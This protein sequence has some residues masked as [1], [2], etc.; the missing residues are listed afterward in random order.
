MTS[1]PLRTA[2]SPIFTRAFNQLVPPVKLDAR[3]GGIAP[4]VI[5][6]LD[7]SKLLPTDFL[8]L[9]KRR[10]YVI[11]SPECESTHHGTLAYS[12]DRPFPRGTRG[13]FYFRKAAD[14]E[15]K[16]EVPVIGGSFRF[17]ITPS[18]DPRSFQDGHDLQRLGQPWGQKLIDAVKYPYPKVGMLIRD[19][20]VQR[21]DVQDV[22]ALPD[23][24]P[25]LVYFDQWFT[26]LYGGQR[27]GLRTRVVWRKP[28]GEWETSL[29]D[30]MSMVAVPGGWNTG[31]HG[32]SPIQHGA[33]RA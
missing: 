9:S 30:D 20:L 19:G 22:P 28:N 5:S 18:D 31:L 7:P 12:G 25:R 17:R 11:T 3:T 21:E 2:S 10:N 6:T 32:E 4:K 1:K 14:I 24:A 16:Y 29:I 23:A 27:A 8:D 26:V 33:D 13:F 15:S